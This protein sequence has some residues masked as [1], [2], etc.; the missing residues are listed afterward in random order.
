M[1]SELKS[2]E[3]QNCPKKFISKEELR[4]HNQAIHENQA[5]VEVCK[6]FQKSFKLKRYLDRHFK[7][8][9]GGRNNSYE[10]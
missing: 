6:I 2:H 3:C 5:L 4:S 1:H 9:H 8:A 7:V 10:M